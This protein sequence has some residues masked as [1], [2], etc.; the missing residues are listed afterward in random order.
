MLTAVGQI[1]STQLTKW[2]RRRKKRCMREGRDRHGGSR[3][4]ADGRKQAAVG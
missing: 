1:G 4:R 3:A 2:A